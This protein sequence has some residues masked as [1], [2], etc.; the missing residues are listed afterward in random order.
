M[1][2][3]ARKTQSLFGGSLTPTGNLSIWGSLALNGAASYSGDPNVLQSAAWLQG[4]NQSLIGNRSPTKEDL[5]A[6]FYTLTWQLGYLLER[7]I[8]EWDPSGN[9]NYYQGDLARVG[10]TVY[11]VTTAGPVGA[12]SPASDTNNWATYS[13]TLTGPNLIRAFAVFQG[14]G[15]IG[16]CT[17]ASSFNV[18][19][20]AKTANGSY[21]ATFPGGVFPDGNY[22][23]AGSAGTPNGVQSAGGD[24]NVL[25]GGG[26][27]GTTAIRTSTQCQ[28]FN[29]EANDAG[30]GV[31]EDVSLGSIMFFR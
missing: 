11:Q 6:M 9:T 13:S 31:L 28:F 10:S 15:A 8:P 30:S 22:G 18:T 21:L 27:I 24:N 19:S 16:N 14:N 23:F 20:I 4:F 1:P 25:C 29:W 17:L 26:V 3:I 2:G 7:G 12:T 5:A